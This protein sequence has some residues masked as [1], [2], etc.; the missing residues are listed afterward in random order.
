MKQPLSEK[1]PQQPRPALVEL[2]VGT[3]RLGSSVGQS[4]ELDQADSLELEQAESLCLD[5]AE[6]LCLEGQR[7]SGSH[8]FSTSAS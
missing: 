6:S 7:F 5:L 2:P 1:L 8:S 3:Y 4:L